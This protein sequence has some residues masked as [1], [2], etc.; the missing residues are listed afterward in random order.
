MEGLIRSEIGV[1]GFVV[2]AVVVVGVFLF[3]CT[4]VM[5]GVLRCDDV[6]GA[7]VWLL[8]LLLG[9]VVEGEGRWRGEADCLSPTAEVGGDDRP[10]I[11][12]TPIDGEA[13]LLLVVG[14]AG[15]G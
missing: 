10:S 14:A 11:I 6:E 8:L 7:T 1:V 15:D 4:E 13:L 9:A 2:T 12:G 3:E 5:E